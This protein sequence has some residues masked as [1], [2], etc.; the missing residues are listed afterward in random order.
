MLRWAQFLRH[1]AE[2]SFLSTSVEPIRDMGRPFGLGLIRKRLMFFPY[3]SKLVSA[4]WTVF[5]L[6]PRIFAATLGRSLL[7]VK[8]VRDLYMMK[9]RLSLSFVERRRYV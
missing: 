3:C 2:R 8:S 6:S 4:E 7:Y 9:I 1:L 5:G